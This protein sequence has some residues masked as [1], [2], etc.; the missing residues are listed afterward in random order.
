MVVVMM[1]MWMLVKGD[2]SILLVRLI[3]VEVV[4]AI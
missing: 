4:L 2:A 3:F 1:V